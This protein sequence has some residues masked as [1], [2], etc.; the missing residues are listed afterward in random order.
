[1]S[2]ELQNVHNKLVTFLD[3]IFLLKFVHPAVSSFPSWPDKFLFIL[4]WFPRVIFPMDLFSHF[5]PT[6]LGLYWLPCVFP[7]HLFHTYTIYSF[8]HYL[9][10]HILNDYSVLEYSMLTLPIYNSLPHS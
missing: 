4:G 1:M 2:T 6:Y 10:K 3:A 9:N 7:D 5:L 8:A